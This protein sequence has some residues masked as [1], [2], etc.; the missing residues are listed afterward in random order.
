M[1]NDTYSKFFYSELFFVDILQLV[2]YSTIAIII[3]TMLLKP[4]DFI[5]KFIQQI[6]TL[7]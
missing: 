4:L 1:V 7:L 2:Y 6:T 3:R 5:F